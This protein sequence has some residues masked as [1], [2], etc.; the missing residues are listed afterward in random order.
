MPI[1]LEKLSSILYRRY[2]KAL[3]L[4]LSLIES[5]QIKEHIFELHTHTGLVVS[6]PVRHIELIEK[7]F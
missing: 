4:D 6:Y 7:E 5:C 2:A 1:D 3:E